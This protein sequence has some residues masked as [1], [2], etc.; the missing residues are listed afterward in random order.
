[1]GRGK[2]LG[3]DEKRG[4]SLVLVP[5]TV[6]PRSGR[7]RLAAYSRNS[8]PFSA[9]APAKAS[10]KPSRMDFLPS[11]ITSAGRS[12]NFVFRTNSTTYFV[13]PGICGNG[14]GAQGGFSFAPSVPVYK[15][16]VVLTAPTLHPDPI[17][18]PLS[19]TI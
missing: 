17:K 13:S 1:M 2:Q 3:K 10:P 12:E 16:P 8:F 19:M 9:R 5:I 7:P 15:Q 4:G 6:E 14:A 11:S 18:S